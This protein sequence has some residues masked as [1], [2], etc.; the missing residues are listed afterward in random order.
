MSDE[1]EAF[2]AHNGVLGMKWGHHK[3]QTPSATTEAKS[4]K[5]E[6]FVQRSQIGQASRVLYDTAKGQGSQYT[7]RQKVGSALMVGGVATQVATVAIGATYY[8]S[9]AYGT[10][11]LHRI[12]SAQRDALENAAKA[13]LNRNSKQL[14]TM[15][16]YA[17]RKTATGGWG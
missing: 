11:K 7:K 4:P 8:G 5:K 17:L 9:R 14:A 13:F 3:A 12:K 15:S 10:L 16:V 6:N 1:V 2:L